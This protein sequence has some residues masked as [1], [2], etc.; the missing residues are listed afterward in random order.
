MSE[1]RKSLAPLVS[2]VCNR[3]GITH[4]LDF[5]CGDDPIMVHLKV[6][7]KMKIQC[8]DPK[9]ERFKETA[10][11]GELVFYSPEVTPDVSIL[12]EVES[13]TGVVCVLALKTETPE[14]WILPMLEKYEL[15]TFQRINEGFYAILYCKPN[16]KIETSNGA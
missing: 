14:E 13:L 4:L 7:Q 3:L 1:F 16:I 10:L 6:N 11:A 5:H 9:V 15:Q 2:Q 8:Y 12:D